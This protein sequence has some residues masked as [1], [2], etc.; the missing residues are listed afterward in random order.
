[1]SFLKSKV[2]STSSGNLAKGGNGSMFGKQSVGNKR[3]GDTA[4]AE[5]GAKRGH[6]FGKQ[7]VD[8]RVSGK[9]GK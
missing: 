8:K 5:G 7:T 2:I 6:M 3:A 4:K 1:M 9:T